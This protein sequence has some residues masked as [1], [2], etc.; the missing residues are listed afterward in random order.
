MNSRYWNVLR[1]NNS[2]CSINFEK[3]LIVFE[4][5]VVTFRFS[6][7]QHSVNPYA[8]LIFMRDFV[9]WIIPAHL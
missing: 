4:E 5:R 9:R 8:R 1:F 7:Q 3:Y 6:H 2:E